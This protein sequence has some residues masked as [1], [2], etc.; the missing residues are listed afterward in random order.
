MTQF[1]NAGLPPSDK[2]KHVL[3]RQ[4]LDKL[5]RNLENSAESINTEPDSLTVAAL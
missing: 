1:A 4:R 5:K 2:L 3:Q